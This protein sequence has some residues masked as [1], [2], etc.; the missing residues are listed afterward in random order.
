MKLKFK[1]INYY[2]KSNKFLAKTLSQSIIIVF[3]ASRTTLWAAV[4]NLQLSFILVKFKEDV[5]LDLKMVFL[6]NLGKNR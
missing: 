4:L 2:I 6:R 3:V 5:R 1:I